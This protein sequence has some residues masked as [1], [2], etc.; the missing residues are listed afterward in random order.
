MWHHYFFAFLL[1]SAPFSILGFQKC[2]RLI[3]YRGTVKAYLGRAIHALLFS[4]SLAI[5]FQ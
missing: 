2:P 3:N 5:Y 4:A 1:I